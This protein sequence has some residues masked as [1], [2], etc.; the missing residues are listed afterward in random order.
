M[1]PWNKL[2][3][4]NPPRI[5]PKTIFYGSPGDDI[6]QIVAKLV[7]N[8]LTKSSNIAVNKEFDLN[9]FASPNFFY[10]KRAE[11]KSIIPLENLRKPKEF[12]TLKSSSSRMLFIE[13]GEDIRIDGY[14]ALLKVVEESDPSTFIWISAK[15]LRPI[16]ATIFSRFEKL[17]I[18]SPT[19]NQIKDHLLAEGLAANEKVFN[20][21]AE[22]PTVMAEPNFYEM[23]SEFDKAIIKKDIFSIDKT[24]FHIFVDYLIYLNKEQTTELGKEPLMKLKA[25]INAKKSLASAHNLNL[26]VIRLNI[27]SCL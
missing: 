1:Y 19:C 3:L 21:L 15:D 27:N 26:D 13:G 4:Q 14:N 5:Q 24:N 11:D 12:L 25:L 18:P 6:H 2:F 9:S 16:P 17:K 10:L 8:Y 7:K 23:L 22:N 20:F